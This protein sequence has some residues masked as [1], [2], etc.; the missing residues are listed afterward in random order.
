MVCYGH[1]VFGI[2][3]ISLGFLLYSEEGVNHG[4][5]TDDNTWCAMVMGC[6]KLLILSLVL[7]IY[8]EEGANPC[9]TTDD[10]TWCVMVMFFF[11]NVV[12]P[13]AL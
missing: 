11:G 1:Q 8:F 4:K 13:L 7:M 9:N 3:D 10:N 6:W 12:I 2:V 5:R